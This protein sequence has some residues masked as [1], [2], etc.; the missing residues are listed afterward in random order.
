MEARSPMKGTAAVDAIVYA[1]PAHMKSVPCRSPTIVGSVVEIA[2]Y[3]QHVSLS[4][5]TTVN[6]AYQVQC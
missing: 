3:K 2:D 6:D 1:L 4:I 5:Y